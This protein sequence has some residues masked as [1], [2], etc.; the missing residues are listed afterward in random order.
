MKILSH[1]YESE[2]ADIILHAARG[3][4]YVHKHGLIGNK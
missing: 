2:Q 4:F 1:R 3:L